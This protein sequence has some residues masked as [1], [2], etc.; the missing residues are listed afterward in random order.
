VHDRLRK[1]AVAAVAVVAVV[2]LRQ[3]C[4]AGRLGRVGKKKVIGRSYGV[5]VETPKYLPYPVPTA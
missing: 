4:G 5:G 3:G 1:F 2:G